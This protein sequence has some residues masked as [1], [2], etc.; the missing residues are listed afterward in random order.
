MGIFWA[1]VCRG[2][3]ERKSGPGRESMGTK[4]PGAG[5]EANER[6]DGGVV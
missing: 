1:E 6:D 4:G 2:C 5:E 3:G